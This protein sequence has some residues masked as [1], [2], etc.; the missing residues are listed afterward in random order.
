VT[1]TAPPASAGIK[2]GRRRA[3]CAIPGQAVQ[4][5]RGRFEPGKLGG[6]QP[7]PLRTRTITLYLGTGVKREPPGSSPDGPG[8]AN[9]SCDRIG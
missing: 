1:A 8:S 3:R 9:S 7:L 2:A 4:G 6:E 5:R